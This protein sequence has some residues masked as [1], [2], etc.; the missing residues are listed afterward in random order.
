MS[1]NLAFAAQN[2]VCG[3][4]SPPSTVERIKIHTVETMR[5]EWG[6]R[7]VLTSPASF[8]RHFM[9]PKRFLAHFQ[10]L[11]EK[12]KVRKRV[13][14][15]HHAGGLSVARIAGHPDVLKSKATVQSMIKTFGSCPTMEAKKSPGRS[16]KMTFRYISSSLG[17]LPG[18]KETCVD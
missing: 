16:T 14:E 17:Y 9:A 5:V 8:L 6:Q 15:L 2:N 11:A 12:E 18:S 13:L 10:A 4:N 1:R 7:R 3:H